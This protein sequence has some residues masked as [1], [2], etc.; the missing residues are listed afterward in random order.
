ME[1]LL[2]HS[3]TV[4][5]NRSKIMLVGQGRA[6]KT[7][8]ANNM[9]GKEFRKGTES[10]IGA[11][12][13]ERK[14]MCGM[15]KEGEK[16]AILEE[17]EPFT[18][19]ELESAMAAA[20]AVKMKMK[21]KL[22][23]D[24]PLVDSLSLSTE[25]D[26]DAFSETIVLSLPDVDGTT[27]NTCL[28]ENIAR[29]DE[30]S[31][32]V[33]SLY[34]FGGQDIFNVLHPFF[35][36]KYGVYVVVFDMELFLSKEAEKRESCM[37]HLKFWMNSIVM[38]TSLDE[39][40]QRTAPVAI[41]GTKKDIICKTEDHKKISQI[42]EDNFRLSSVWNSLLPIRELN[43]LYF[44]PV[45]N[46]ERSSLIG[47]VT[48]LLKASQSF[49]EATSFVKKK[50]PFVW[51]K[52]FDKIKEKKDSF[53]TLQEVVKMCERF[54]LSSE[55]I[56]KMLMYFSEMG[57]LIWVNEANL[58]D[59][60]ILDPI[61]YFVKPA[62][63]IICKHIATTDDPS[64]TV[65]CEEIHE[66]SRKEWPKDWYQMLEFGL[67][68]DRLARRLLES[69]CTGE[70][71]VEKVLVLMKRYGLL[72]GPDVNYFVPALVPASPDVL[73][74]PDGDARILTQEMVQRLEVRFTQL[75]SMNS[76]GYFVFHFAFSLTYDSLNIPLLS[77]RDISVAGFLPSGLY[78]RFVSSL[79][80][81]IT[82]GEG[83]IATFL[84][85]N[86][87]MTFQH[88][89]Q[90]QYLMK[91]VRIINLPENNMIRV[92]VGKDLGNMNDAGIL[93]AIHDT[94]YQLIQELIRECFG[95][96]VVFTLLPCGVEFS[97]NG[98][99]LPL[100]ELNYLIENKTLKVQ[101]ISRDGT[102]SLEATVSELQALF[103]PFLTLPSVHPS[104]G[105]YVNLVMQFLLYFISLLTCISFCF[106]RL[107]RRNMMFFFL[108]IG[109][110]IIKIMRE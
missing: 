95:N 3:Q 109:E 25:N 72:V 17:Y 74:I 65:H 27:F 52:I 26:V 84:E 66:S 61:E 1:S 86:L 49:L 39:L 90:I 75:N 102:Q 18:P 100:M 53:L 108:M 55:E 98:P 77:S 92:E 36:S 5:W 85:R 58:R 76:A 87:F 110:V 28:S 41:V 10:T 97:R 38:H 37:K 29:K 24:N 64:H 22:K 62:T 91:I 59:I 42:L 67:V 103:S 8:L 13:F 106:F 14:L 50:V 70:H 104:K 30:G 16:G 45:N 89:I 83:N 34:D 57:I 4:S 11:E 105:L 88:V 21:S 19:K 44:F 23:V 51:L 56:T 9:M 54:S 68:S 78:E 33:I 60:V 81:R 46:V 2:N 99:F 40:K 31:E 73:I 69:A 94:F 35:M 47:A 15:M 80:Q 63:I 48:Q 6:G 96:L 43:G 32:L 20:A 71:H 12:R 101:Y 7:A 79:F 107:L 82:V 93:I